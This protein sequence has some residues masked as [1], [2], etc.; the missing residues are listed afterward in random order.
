M[1]L[2]HSILNKVIDMI[3]IKYCPTMS[4]QVYEHVYETVDINS[5]PEV[6]ANATAKVDPHHIPSNKQAFDLCMFYLSQFHLKHYDKK[7]WI[8]RNFKSVKLLCSFIG[9][10]GSFRSKWG[11]L[12]STRCR[13]AQDRR[14]PGFQYNGRKGA[15][16]TNIHLSDH[17]RRHRRPTRRLEEGRSA[18]LCQW[19]GMFTLQSLAD[20]DSL[21][22]CMHLHRIDTLSSSWMGPS[23]EGFGCG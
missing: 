11:T 19:G 9:Y 8:K 18:S 2:L 10:S 12:T 13:T 20:F 21:I 22:T 5:S 6:R 4:L 1:A 16:L 17:P 14:R 3:V 23:Y 7:Q 15:K